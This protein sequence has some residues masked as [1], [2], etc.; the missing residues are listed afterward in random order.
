MS[1]DAGR[2]FTRVGATASTNCATGNAPATCNDMNNDFL[3]VAYDACGGYV[4]A[5]GHINGIARIRLGANESN[6]WT[7]I[8]EGIVTDGPD[9]WQNETIIPDI[10][11]DPDNGGAGGVCSQLCVPASVFSFHKLLF[12]QV[13]LDM[14][15]AT[16]AIHVQSNPTAPAALSACFSTCRC[17]LSAYRQSSHRV[18]PQHAQPA[19]DRR[20]PNAAGWQQLDTPERT[21]VLVKSARGVGVMCTKSISALCVVAAAVLTAS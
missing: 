18:T 10:K 5:G 15:A 19:Q 8:N 9:L 12:S 21:G 20:L 16:A 13:G 7:W 6:S 17:I 4:Y 2:T 11:V 14:S 3:A 1:D